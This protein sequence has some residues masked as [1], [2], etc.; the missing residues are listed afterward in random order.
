MTQKVFISYSWSSPNHEDWVINLAEKLISDG[1]D[2]VL[3]K[4]DLKEGHDLYDFMETTVKSNEIHKVLI[5][6]D[7]SYSEK[8]DKRKGGVGTE[9]QIISPEIYSNVSQEKF[10]PIVAE[11]DE[12][13]NE[14]V[15][16]YLKGRVYIDLSSEE[17]YEENY[18]KLLRNIYKRPSQS[19]PKLGTPPSYLFEDS[20]VTHKTTGIIRGLDAQLLKHPKRIN[21]LGQDFF[22]DFYTNLKE[23]EISFSSRDEFEIGKE[24]C[25]NLTKFTPL[26]D[27]FIAFIDKV[28]KLDLEYELDIDIIIKFFEKLPL[29]TSPSGKSS[30]ME[31]EYDNFRFMI[32]ELFLYLIAIP[33]KNS[34]YK[35]LEEIFYASYFIKDKYD[36]KKDPGTFADFY[37][38]IDTI[39]VYYNQKFSKNFHS[40]MADFLVSRMP[41]K[42]EKADFV[43]ADLL[44]YYIS[45]LKDLRW[46]PRTYIYKG[47]RTSFELFDRLVSKK[48]FE[49]VK[50]LFDVQT[51]E[52]LKQKIED[53][54]KN[55]TNQ[56]RIG[57][58]GS[59]NSVSPIY[60][61]IN[62]ET[63]AT[64]R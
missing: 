15:P 2:V 45:I 6:L 50:I 63:L 35:F 13:G 5:I 23:F 28:S 18:E 62:V 49:K 24:I 19:K 55:D 48:H 40:P 44:C 32:S 22:D 37:Y 3:D 33:L 21:S 9:T 7:K 27:D 43:D 31:Y 10:I 12:E 57:Y 17:H 11:R 14:F 64:L 29:L 41:G 36:Y 54:K 51:S 61:I 20:P 52:N 8:A 25:E 39:N 1:I 47:D 46:F 53:I 38:H 59:F 42:L 34:N 30:W 4:W 26:R 58:S 56:H 60:N 16:T